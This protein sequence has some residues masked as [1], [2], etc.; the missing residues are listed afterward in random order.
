MAEMLPSNVDDPHFREEPAEASSGNWLAEAVEDLWEN[1]FYVPDFLAL[2]PE[3]L[4]HV[5]K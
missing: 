2:L 1:R 3:A 5:L 4:H